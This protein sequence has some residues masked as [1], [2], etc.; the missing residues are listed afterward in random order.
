MLVHGKNY[1]LFLFLTI[2]LS[3]YSKVPLIKVR[4]GKN[5]KSVKLSGLDIKKQINGRRKTNSY[6]GKKN[7]RFNCLKLKKLKKLKSPL[8]LASL[9]S[10]TGLI[11]WEDTAYPG[12]LNIV[13][14]ANQQGCDL[15]NEIPLETYLTS[16]LA[17]EMNAVWP[18]E[19]LKAQAVAARTYAYH[20][21]V[22][23]QVSRTKGFKTYYDLENS[24]KHQVNG[25]FFDSTKQTEFASKKTFGEVLTLENG[26]LTPI[27]FHAKCGGKTLKP[28]QVWSN[29][30]KGY[31]SVNC[32]FCHKL[33]KK[34]WK[35]VLPKKSF[36]SVINKTLKNFYH[37]KL[38]N[39]STPELKIVPDNKSKTQLRLY[40][41]DRL[42]TLQKSRIRSVLG[43]GKAPSNYYQLEQKGNKIILRG[44][45]HGHG[46][47]MCQ[48]G[49][50]EMA[51]RGWNY[52]QILSHYFPRHQLKKIY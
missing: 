17:K 41:D 38:N 8:L 4:I 27:F 6:L 34:D 52:K 28:S 45:G 3:G 21:M 7:L 47:G 20:K 35:L 10:P 43:R 11:R 15:I 13:A 50:L 37:D 25:S 23:Q 2:S 30:I 24:E 18:I 33:G 1:I 16:L 29:E 51:K 19:A 26:K 32:P 12:K 31:E 42:L 5:L 14:A 44:K 36:Y 9:S 22:T 40:D 49:A 39:K 48:L 46:V